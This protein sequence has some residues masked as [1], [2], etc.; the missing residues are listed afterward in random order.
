MVNWISDYLN[1][2][3]H[4]PSCWR[5][6]GPWNIIVIRHFNYSKALNPIFLKIFD[7][8]LRDYQQICDYTYVIV[9]IICI[10]PETP[11][12][13]DSTLV[14][15]WQFSLQACLTRWVFSPAENCLRLW[16][17]SWREFQTTRTENIKLMRP[18]TNGG[19][20]DTIKSPGFAER[21]LVRPAVARWQTL[22][23]RLL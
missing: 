19:S 13:G 2:M 8:L 23:R 12:V 4:G 6:L 20:C 14:T 5:Q 21:R 3:Q 7:L 18:V 16:R 17:C 22:K 11:W 1:S 9:V 15:P 10:T